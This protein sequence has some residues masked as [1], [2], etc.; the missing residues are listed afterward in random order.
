[1]DNLKSTSEIYI[2]YVHTGINVK[3]ST[4]FYVL[5]NA[6]IYDR[7]FLVFVRP[8]VVDLHRNQ[9]LETGDVLVITWYSIIKRNVAT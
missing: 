3:I 2:L 8:G 7:C 1:M 4:Q 6:M 9:Q 5:F